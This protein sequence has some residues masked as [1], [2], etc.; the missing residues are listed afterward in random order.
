MRGL[1]IKD[2]TQ[3]HHRRMLGY[4]GRP[5][6]YGWCGGG[7]P[8]GRTTSKTFRS[9]RVRQFSPLQRQPHIKQ[10]SP[11]A[12]ASRSA[13]SAYYSVGPSSLA[14]LLPMRQKRHVPD[15]VFATMSRPQPQPQPRASPLIPRPVPAPQPRTK[16]FSLP[17][18]LSRVGTPVAKGTWILGR[19]SDDSEGGNGYVRSM[20]QAPCAW[21]DRPGAEPPS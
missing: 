3:S 8:A 7:G 10:V 6:P 9:R 5:V 12:Q 1:G 4:V 18:A 11:L 21:D 13:F 2:L 20:S 16:S 15:S 19:G 14:S 17:N